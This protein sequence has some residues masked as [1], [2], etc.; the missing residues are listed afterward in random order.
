MCLAIP[1]KILEIADLATEC[2]RPALVAFGG[3]SREVNLCF[4]PEAVVGDYVLVHVGV[5]ISL[6]DETEAQ[7]TLQYLR[8]MGEMDEL[9]ENDRA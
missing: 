4:L 6:V 8:S 7:L 1:G 9:T 2:N 3:I 5:A